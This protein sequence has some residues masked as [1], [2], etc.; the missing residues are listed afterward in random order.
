MDRTIR[1]DY[2][3]TPRRVSNLICC[4]IESG[5]MITWAAKAEF[6]TWDTEGSKTRVPYG[7]R[8]WG[9]YSTFYS[10]RWSIEIT[11]DEGTVH[12]LGWKKLKW[13]LERPAMKRHTADFLDDNEDVETADALVQ[14]AI[15][16]EIV[17]G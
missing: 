1:F 4:F 5:G 12:T 16:K 15:F 3:I 10:G 11:D 7:E 13:A 2:T 8:V 9:Y 14:T 6:F 17:Y